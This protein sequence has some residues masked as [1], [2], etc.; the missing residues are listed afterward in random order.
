[1][2][3]QIKVTRILLQILA[4]NRSYTGSKPT[5]CGFA[6]FGEVLRGI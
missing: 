5:V 2:F 6:S 1:M 4:L 3:T